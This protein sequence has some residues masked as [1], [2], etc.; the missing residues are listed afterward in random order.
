MSDDLTRSLVEAWGEDD[1]EGWY[2]EGHVDALAMAL[3]VLV[4]EM[5]LTS[6]KEAAEHLLTGTFSPGTIDVPQDWL[7]AAQH[8][9]D[10]VGYLWARED[11]DR[12][13]GFFPCEQSDEGAEPW[14]ELRL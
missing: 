7:T 10:S 11:E 1:G 13:E 14:T 9:V 2:A 6:P 8:L 3:S 5:N 4:M 12:G